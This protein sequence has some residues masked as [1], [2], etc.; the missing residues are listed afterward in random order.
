MSDRRNWTL[1]EKDVL[2][3]ILKGIVADGGRCDTG[4][5]RSGIYDQVVSKMREKIENI[6][7]TAK[8]VQNKMKRMKDKYSAAYDMLNTSGFGWD[9]T[10]KCVTVDAPEILEEYLKV[11]GYINSFYI[12]N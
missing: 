9:D 3:S 11:S 2:I 5:F 6:T 7:I 8:H 12:C 10:H 1:E 4:S